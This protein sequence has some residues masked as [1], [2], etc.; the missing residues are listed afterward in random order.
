MSWAS[1]VLDVLFWTHLPKWNPIIST[2]IS[3][4]TIATTTGLT[5]NVSWTKQRIAAMISVFSNCKPNISEIKPNRYTMDKHQD[6]HYYVIHVNKPLTRINDEAIATFTQVRVGA[7]LCWGESSANVAV[8]FATKPSTS[9]ESMIIVW[10]KA[11]REE[12]KKILG[13]IWNEN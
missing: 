6:H 9:E 2:S 12:K 11:K 3:S 5:I 1:L 13:L 8:K 7:G 4:I 10:K